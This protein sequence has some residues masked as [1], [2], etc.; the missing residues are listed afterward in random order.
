M[1][2]LGRLV[3]TP[4][5]SALGWAIFH[6]LWEGL[7]VAVA[8]ALFLRGTR[9][10]R[11]RYAGACLA[12]MVIFLAAAVTLGRMMPEPGRT[13]ATTITLHIPARAIEHTSAARSKHFTMSDIVPWLTPLWIAGVLLFNLRAGASWMAA[14]RLR[15]KGVCLAPENWQRRAQDLAE[16]LGLAHAAVLLESSLAAGPA[17]VGFI[18]PVILTPVGMLTGMPTSQV[19]SI[20]L[21]ELAHV[22]RHDY[23]A[24]LLQTVVEGLLFYHPAVW[25][26]SHVVRTE[27]ENCCDDLVVNASGNAHD[28]AAALS[29]LAENR[30]ASLALP[31]NG[32]SLMKRIRRLLYPEQTSPSFLLPLLSA[33]VFTLVTAWAATAWQAPAEATTPSAAPHL[34]TTQYDRLVERPK[35]PAA[36]TIRQFDRLKQYGQL[37]PHQIAQVQ[38]A[39]PRAAPPPVDAPAK[40]PEVKLM[41]IFVNGELKTFR[42][43]RVQ[44]PNGRPMYVINGRPVIAQ[45]QAPF[46]VLVLPPPP[47]MGEAYSRWLNEDVVYIITDEERQAFRRL[48][49]DAERQQFVEQFW[50]RRDPT[51]GTPLNEMEEEHYRRVAYANNRFVERADVPGWKTDRGRIY[52][53]FGPPDELDSHG[54]SADGKPPTE[55]W[56][57]RLIQGVGT[58]VI[59]DFVDRAANGEYHM[60]LDPNHVGGVRLQ[61]PR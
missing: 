3:Q 27:R 51:P 38:Q 20:L 34:K 40:A 8:F 56:R 18:R 11:V 30:L 23:L 7:I 33:A 61:Q 19:E 17:V 26:I 9:S 55:T 21:H 39:D 36:P 49:T 25:W 4:F 45:A 42:A 15:V 28:Y 47:P 16:H 60:T 1:M 48:Q 53:V 50:L 14:R 58:D 13:F 24:N 44:M 12:M 32:G 41:D 10:A 37:A 31:A 59:I 2:P 6:S 57:Y 22:R 35:S 52:I 43:E 29:M 5:A 46:P 54:V